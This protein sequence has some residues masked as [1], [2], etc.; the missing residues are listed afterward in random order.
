MKPSNQS[1]SSDRKLGKD[2][3]QL[4]DDLGIFGQSRRT[5]LNQMSAAG[6]S[7]MAVPYFTSDMFAQA[8]KAPDLDP[9]SL[10]NALEVNL[11]INGKTYPLQVDSRMTLLDALRERLNLTGSKKGCDHGQCGACTVLIDG[12]R[13]LSCLT[14][15]ATCK[16]KEVT[17]VEGLTQGTDLH[18]VQAA[19]LKHDG[20]QCGYCTPGQICSAVSLLDEAKRGEVSYVTKNVKDEVTQL[21]D[22]EIRERMS[23]NICRCGAYNNIVQAIQEVHSGK[24]EMPRWEFATEEQLE[25]SR[26]AE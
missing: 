7:L 18:P 23:G 14:L 13:K 5:F 4:L 8:S 15:S 1:A 16:D 20:F 26:P 19:F 3:E 22:E 11:K 10:L 25:A 17:T 12:K 24:A 2:E 9:E 21:S 6:I